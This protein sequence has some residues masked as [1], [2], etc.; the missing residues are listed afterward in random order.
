MDY[1]VR[2]V[3]SSFDDVFYEA[4][5]PDLTVP[6]GERVW[7]FCE[8]GWL[9]GRNPSAFFDTVS[10]LTTHTDVS[11]INMNPLFHFVVQGR[12]EGRDVSPSISPS[13]RSRLIF[14]EPV[15]EWVSLVRPFID[16]QFYSSQL[17]KGL[18]DIVDLAAHFA[19]TG[20]RIGLS[21]SQDVQLS[22]LRRLYPAACLAMVNPLIAHIRGAEQ[23]PMA[24]AARHTYAT[25]LVASEA[26]PVQY[27]SHVGDVAKA[28]RPSP[29]IDGIRSSF[30]A[31]F[32]LAANPDVA[33]ADVDP[34]EHYFYTGWREGRAPSPDFDVNYYLSQN[35]DVAALLVEPYW[36][37]LTVGRAER[38]PARPAHYPGEASPASQMAIVGSEFSPTYYLSTYPDVAASGIDP[39]E[40]YTNAGWREGRNPTEEFDTRYYLKSNDDVRA[41]GVNPFWHYLV[42]GRA[43]GRLPV[44]PG[45]FRREIIE[46]AVAPA[47]RVRNWPAV[48]GEMLSPE[49]LLSSLEFA[50]QDRGSLAVAFSHDCYINVVGGTQIFIADEQ[51]AFERR[52][53][54]YLHISPRQ[55]MLSLAPLAEVFYTQV[56]LNGAH[57]GLCE[58]SDLCQVLQTV[59]HEDA[60][61]RLFIVHSVFGFNECGLHDLYL[62]TRPTRAVFWIHDYSSICEGFNLLRNDLEYCGAPPSGSLSCRVCI[63]GEGRTAYRG[64]IRWLFERCTF[65]VLA[66]SRIALEIWERA[67]ELP[68]RSAQSHPHWQLRARRPRGT[69]LI[70]GQQGTRSA[71]RVAFVGFPAAQK[72]WPVFNSLVNAFYNDERYVFVHFGATGANRTSRCEFVLTEVSSANRLGT[73]QLLASRQI[74]FLLV[75]STWP[76]T[77]SFVAHEGLAAGCYVLCL[78]DSGNVAAVVHEK[79]AGQVFST[80]QDLID[81][82]KG[83][84]ATNAAEERRRTA[85]QYSIVQRGTTATIATVR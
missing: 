76:E 45:G 64:R 41:S 80:V 2:R 35:P 67:A 14:G 9:E 81:F 43:E 75:L 34:L 72:G 3:A 33:S 15:V 29:S 7:H 30:D 53:V 56:V 47:E 12:K 36:H 69:N 21:P 16:A 55:P 84:E 4:E 57:L 50:L 63:Y 61:E 83:G 78:R 54:T 73:V 5:Y 58:I 24:E 51:S 42:A 18:A 13:V 22:E 26:A 70:E 10:Y 8:V 62:S 52:G 28:V 48:E 23:V 25:G 27:G 49:R 71:V 59:R 68:R 37:Y 77:F 38:R 6:E 39:V 31:S 66:P 60:S 20:W 44:Q 46:S 74:D 1:I 17:P 65:D 82:F 40:H 11:S 85:V 32:Y 79:G 19:F